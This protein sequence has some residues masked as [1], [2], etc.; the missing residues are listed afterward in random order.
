MKLGSGGAAEDFGS[1]GSAEL[2][3]SRFR[4]G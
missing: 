4:P 3:N 2:Q 1:V